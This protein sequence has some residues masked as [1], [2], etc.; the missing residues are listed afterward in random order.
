MTERKT[1]S[2]PL[3]V[4]LFWPCH[5]A[6]VVVFASLS[7]WYNLLLSCSTAIS[8]PIS[9]LSKPLFSN[10][11]DISRAVSLVRPK[12][13][14]FFCCCC[15]CCCCC[16]SLLRSIH[17][18]SFSFF[19]FLFFYSFFFFFF[20]LDFL[21]SIFVFSLNL[22]SCLLCWA[23]VFYGFLGFFHSVFSYY[24]LLFMTSF[25]RIFSSLI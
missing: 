24:Q 2:S 13:N 19:F 10:V 20:F 8:D 25:R 12:I 4:M 7:L 17:H 22:F 16:C 23:N 15:C 5:L 21:S 11:P 18:C 1:R 6:L 3:D 9:V 14:A